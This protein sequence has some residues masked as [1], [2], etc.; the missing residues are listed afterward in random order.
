[1]TAGHRPIAGVAWA[2]TRSIERVEVR[3]DDDPWQPA[4]LSGVLSDSSWVQ[5]THGWDAT[6]G[7]H[8]LQVR[9][10][11]GDGDPQT[12]ELAPPAP[13]GATGYHTVRVEVT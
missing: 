11:D 4:R 12:A 13:S 9:A 1:M 7:A 2:P 6:P 3:V 10:T 5:W 8:R